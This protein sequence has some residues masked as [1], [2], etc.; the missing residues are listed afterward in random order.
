MFP[1]QKIILNLKNNIRI[2]YSVLK[3]RTIKNKHRKTSKQHRMYF[4]NV[5]TRCFYNIMTTE[6]IKEIYMADNSKMPAALAQKAET[7]K[8]GPFD[9]QAL[10]RKGDTALV[11]TLGMIEAG[12]YHTEKKAVTWEDSASE[13]SSTANSLKN[14]AQPKNQK[15]LK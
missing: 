1:Y 11:I 12:P 13:N 10:Q 7:I 14:S 9:W 3:C 5:E 4:Q 8:F 2:D 15:L 6:K